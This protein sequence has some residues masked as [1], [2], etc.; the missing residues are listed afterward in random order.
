MQFYQTLLV[1]LASAST[2][3]GGPLGDL[4]TLPPRD[5]E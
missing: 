5:C 3:F 2:A 1:M 4:K